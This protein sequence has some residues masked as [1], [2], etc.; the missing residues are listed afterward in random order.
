MISHNN[1]NSQEISIAAIK[2]KLKTKK[3]MRMFFASQGK[4]LIFI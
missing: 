2:S 1:N 3:D 4:Y